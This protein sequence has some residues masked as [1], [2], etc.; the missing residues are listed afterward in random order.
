MRGLVPVLQH[1]P[2]DHD[3]VPL[4]VNLLRQAPVSI[5]MQMEGLAEAMAAQL[6]HVGSTRGTALRISRSHLPKA[7]QAARE[8]NLDPAPGIKDASEQLLVQVH[9]GGP[10][11]LYPS[12]DM[13]G[14]ADFDAVAAEVSQKHQDQVLHLPR[15]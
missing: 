13:R 1:W 14:D 10:R 15:C 8:S 11:L 2:L 3:M 6:G 5:M 4:V 12:N 9:C 7:A